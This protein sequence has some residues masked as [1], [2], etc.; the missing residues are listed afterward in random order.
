LKPLQI[1]TTAFLNPGFAIL[2]KFFR[3]PDKIHIFE[4]LLTSFGVQNT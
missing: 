2:H 3:T 1:H 4:R